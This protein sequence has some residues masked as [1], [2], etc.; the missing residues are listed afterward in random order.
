MKEHEMRELCIDMMCQNFD[1]RIEDFKETCCGTT[2]IESPIEN[3]LY[4]ALITLFSIEQIGEP[5]P[6]NSGDFVVASGYS[7]SPQ[8]EIGKYRV[9]FLVSYGTDIFSIPE[10]RTVFNTDKELVVEC[11]G[12]EWHE[13][14]EKERRYEKKRDRFIQSEGYKIFRYTGKEITDDPFK[15]AAEIFTQV[16]GRK[17]NAV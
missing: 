16:V 6:E 1:S 11:D 4:S 15:V 7:I 14:T 13:R 9:D 8:Y 5:E 17:P 10:K 12:T 2:P 3:M